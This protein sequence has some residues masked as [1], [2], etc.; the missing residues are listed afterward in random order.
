FHSL[1]IEHYDFLSRFLRKRESHKQDGE[2]LTAQQRSCIAV[3]AS[4]D[5]AMAFGPSSDTNGHKPIRQSGS[6]AAG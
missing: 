4:G 2:T 5:P 3:S 1:S 6:F